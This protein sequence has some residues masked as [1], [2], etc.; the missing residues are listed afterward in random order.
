MIVYESLPRERQ[1]LVA[2]SKLQPT[3]ADWNLLEQEIRRPSVNWDRVV[4]RAFE[5]DIA[6]LMHNSIRR[7]GVSSLQVEQAL[8]RLKAGYHANAI[9]NAIVFQE[10]QKILHAFRE[11]GIAVIVLKGAALAQT[12]YQNWAV[13]PMSDVDLFIR[14]EQFTKAEDL[15]GK[16]SYSPDIRLPELKE[17]HLAHY[18]EIGFTKQLASSFN[19][20]CEIHWRLERPSRSFQIDLH[21][22]WQRA[23]PVA[24]GDVDALVLCPEDLLLHLCLHTCKH[25]L[26]GGFRALCDVSETIRHFGQQLNWDA[27][28]IRATQWQINAFVYVLLRLS[29]QLSGAS[30]P[31]RILNALASKECDE[32]LLDAATERV[33]EDRRHALHFA[34]FLQLRHGQSFGHKLVVLRKAF[35]RGAIANRYSVSPTSRK[36]YRYYP[37]RLK[38]LMSDYLPEV[39]QSVRYGGQ[40]LREAN[41]RARLAAWLAPFD[42]GAS[43]AGLL[44]DVAPDGPHG[45]TRK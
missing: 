35:S 1:L 18:Y 9:R 37:R 36:I 25:R 34:E 27:V 3:S 15:L 44:L 41:G 2:G 22:L 33:L 21:G 40:L 5:H 23:V 42:T 13:R 30:V 7:L 28:L 26:A 4:T 8:S 31:E 20:S 45:G 6:P 43:E 11:C 29:Q 38:D 10:L 16:L 39:W 32:E 17:R 19:V 24:F 14:K 12:V